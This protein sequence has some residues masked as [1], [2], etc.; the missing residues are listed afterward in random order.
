MV[1]DT[2]S[3]SIKHFP[4]LKNHKLKTLKKHFEI[5]KCKSYRAADDSIVTEKV[6]KE[7]KIRTENEI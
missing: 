4:T 5:E 2:L 3:L 1:L 6:Y 7:C